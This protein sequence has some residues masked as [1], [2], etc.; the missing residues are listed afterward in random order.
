MATSRYLTPVT[1]ARRQATIMPFFAQ[2]A[3]TIGRGLTI[4]A[5]VRFEHESLPGEF[6]SVGVAQPPS[7]FP[8]NPISFGWGSKIAPRIGA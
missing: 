3:W 7:G 1:A 2:D 8:A 6:D 4:N 5:G